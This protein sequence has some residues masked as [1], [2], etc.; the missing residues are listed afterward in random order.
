M[1]VMPLL[2]LP[3]H[4]NPLRR[5]Q[6]WSD[7]ASHIQQARLQYHADVLTADHYSLASLMQFYLPDQPTT[8]LPPAPYGASQF[9]LWP[10]YEVKPGTRALYVTDSAR[11]DPLPN[12]LRSQFDQCRLVDD[13]WSHYRSQPIYE[14]RIFLLTKD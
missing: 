8:Y 9:T 5:G 13:F 11:P 3:R 12:A 6:G 2:S 7:F 4:L 14:F 1:H 10:G